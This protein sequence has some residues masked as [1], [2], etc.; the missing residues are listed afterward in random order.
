MKTR[1][2]FVSNSSSSSFTFGLP[3]D[4]DLYKLSIPIV[5]VFH[6]DNIKIFR[7]IDEFMEYLG[8][9]VDDDPD[10][11]EFYKKEISSLKS[12]KC[13]V[14]IE[15]PRDG[16]GDIYSNLLDTASDGTLTIT[17]G[18]NKYKIAHYEEE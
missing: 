9:D 10:T 8:D 7:T 3:Q 13:I 11:L 18:K 4:V 12:G 6:M 1:L 17:D 16:C 14:K 15:S 5:D 2:G